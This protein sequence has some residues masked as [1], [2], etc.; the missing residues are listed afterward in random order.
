MT[1]FGV[2][3]NFDILKYLYFYLHN[4][5]RL[6]KFQWKCIFNLFAS[7]PVYQNQ[8]MYGVRIFYNMQSVTKCPWIKPHFIFSFKTIYQNRSI[9][10]DEN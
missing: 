1:M 6:D 10:K 8:A 5:R 3:Y 4:P 7:K 2:N 9:I